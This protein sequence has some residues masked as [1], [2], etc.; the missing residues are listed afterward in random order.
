MQHNLRLE[1]L[2]LIFVWQLSYAY[3]YG[4]LSSRHENPFLATHPVLEPGIL[5]ISRNHCYTF[6]TIAAP[7]VGGGGGCRHVVRICGV[8]ERF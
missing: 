4:V 7:E 8:Q 1:K 2:T 5:S 3:M 6:A